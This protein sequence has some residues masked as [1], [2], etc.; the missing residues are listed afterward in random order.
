MPLLLFRLWPTKYI[1]NK[2]NET[3]RALLIFQRTNEKKGK[4][5][6]LIAQLVPILYFSFRSREMLQSK[7]F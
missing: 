2:T 5:F 1:M 3:S 4:L 6:G 7:R